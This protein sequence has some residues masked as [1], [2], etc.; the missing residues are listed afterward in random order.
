[1]QFS[2]FSFKAVV[3][4]LVG[5]ASFAAGVEF[6]APQ[7]PETGVWIQ[8]VGD[9]MPHAKIKGTLYYTKYYENDRVKSIDL[10]KVNMEKFMKQNI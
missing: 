3:L 1:M 9:I 7:N 4:V 2:K 10:E 8:Q 5:L 6:P